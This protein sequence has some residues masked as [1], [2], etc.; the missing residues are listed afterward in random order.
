MKPADAGDEKLETDAL[1]GDELADEDLEDV[2]GG[3]GHS[4]MNVVP[5]GSAGQDGGIPWDGVIL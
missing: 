5:Q 4:F 2:T 1:C 3:S